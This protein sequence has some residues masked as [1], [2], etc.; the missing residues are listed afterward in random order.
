MTGDWKHTS[1]REAGVT[2]IDCDHRTPPVAHAGYPY[3]AIPQ[4]REGR[5]DLTGVRRISPEHFVE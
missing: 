5:L 4:L 3:V 1:L 2:L